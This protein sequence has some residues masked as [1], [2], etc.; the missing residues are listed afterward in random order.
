MPPPRLDFAPAFEEAFARLDRQA[1]G[2]NF[3]SLADLRPT[4]A[5][6][7]QAFDTGLRELR[8]AGR[9]T[10]SAAEGRHGLSPAE[11]EAAINEDGTLLLFVSR[12]SP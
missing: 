3:V 1:G 11:R 6:D 5:C 10:L 2:H 7:R 8:I 12:K 4:V 9:F